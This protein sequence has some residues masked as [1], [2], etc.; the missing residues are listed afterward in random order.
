MGLLIIN[1]NEKR[2]NEGTVVERLRERLEF[3]HLSKSAT[4]AALSTKL[5]NEELMMYLAQ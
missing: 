5:E 3:L 2:M 4:S 1:P